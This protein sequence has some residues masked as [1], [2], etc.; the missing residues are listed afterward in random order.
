[1]P[2]RCW[3]RRRRCSA[4][5]RSPPSARHEA[6]AQRVSPVGAGVP[7]GAASGVL[8]GVGQRKPF[9][10]AAR[11][12]KDRGWHSGRAGSRLRDVGA[13]DRVLVGRAA[14]AAGIEHVRA[15]GT[16]TK[17][18]A[19]A[20]AAE[21]D[22][23]VERLQTRR[24]WRRAAAR[25]SRPSRISSRQVEFVVLADGMAGEDAGRDRERRGQAAETLP[26][27]LPSAASSGEAVGRPHAP[28]GIARRDE[29][30][31]VAAHV[32]A[33]S[34]R[35][36]P[37]SPRGQSGPETQSPRS[38]ITRPQ[39]RPARSASTA[40]RARTL[41]WMSARTARRMRENP[42]RSK[43]DPEKL[44]TFRKRSCAAT[45]PRRARSISASGDPP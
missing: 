4:R 27:A 30:V 7:F 44:Q 22:R 36:A 15:P 1:M 26:L 19:V 32:A 3:R 9:D 8:P 17:S 18:G 29:P 25:T 21:H 34:R 16:R 6:G 43:H 23:R 5:R 2:R 11:L 24:R 35:G 39:P 33:P 37:S 28:S 38:T 45:R 13:A 31:V 14:D 10:A 42:P 20:V 41:P 40:S 12:R